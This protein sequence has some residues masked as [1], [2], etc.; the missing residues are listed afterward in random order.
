MSSG[1]RRVQINRDREGGQE[2]TSESV[3]GNK[4]PRASSVS[5]PSIRQ[6]RR[7]VLAR[8]DFVC[9]LSHILSG[10]EIKSNVKNTT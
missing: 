1:L 2:M 7:R 3:G 8:V 6:S 4:K 9:L 5:A 10:T